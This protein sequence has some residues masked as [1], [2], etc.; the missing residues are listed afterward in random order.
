VAVNSDHVFCR[1]AWFESK[2]F[3]EPFQ[4]FALDYDWYLAVVE[5]EYLE[6]CPSTP[7]PTLQPWRLPAGYSNLD[8]TDLKIRVAVKLD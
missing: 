2:I 4:N 3:V 1:K 5:M 7:L 8:N 6:K